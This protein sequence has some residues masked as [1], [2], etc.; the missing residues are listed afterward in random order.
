VYDIVLGLY[1]VF[2][3]DR[4]AHGVVGYVVFNA[5][6]VNAMNSDCPIESV[7]DSIVPDV[8][9]LYCSNH[10]EMNRV[11]AQNESLTD[12]GK[13]NTVDSS[14][15]RLVFGRVHDYDSSVLVCFRGLRI[16]LVLDIAGQKTDFSAHF[17]KVTSS[18]FLNTSVM[19]KEKRLFESDHWVS[20]R[21]GDACNLALL[22][23]TSRVVCR[24]DDDFFS[25]FPVKRRASHII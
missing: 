23:V 8:G 18:E 2:D 4:V 25:D 10:V 15:S 1:G 22:C 19:L 14:S 20:A 17:N 16:A 6:V 3:E 13:L 5:Q 21:V 7:M 11:G 24:S 9:R 12:I